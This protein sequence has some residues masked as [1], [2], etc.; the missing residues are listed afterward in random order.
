M[1]RDASFDADGVRASFKSALDGSRLATTREA[2]ERGASLSREGSMRSSAAES[3]AASKRALSSEGS[4]GDLIRENSNVRMSPTI[5]GR[6]AFF[7]GPGPSSKLRVDTLAAEEGTRSPLSPRSVARL[8]ESQRARR[9]NDASPRNASRRLASPPQTSAALLPSQRGAANPISHHV[10]PRPAAVGNFAVSQIT[11]NPFLR[12]AW[13]TIPNPL[14]NRSLRSLSP[15][16][17]SAIVDNMSITTVSVRQSLLHRKQDGDVFVVG[18]QRVGQTPIV[19][20]LASLR[21]GAVVSVDALPDHVLWIESTLCNGVLPPSSEPRIIKTHL[22]LRTVFQSLKTL[23]P[24]YKYV[25]VLREPLDIRVSWFRHC[26][27]IYMHTAPDPSEFDR[28]FFKGADHFSAVSLSTYGVEVDVG[29]S[30]ESYVHEVLQA[31]SVNPTNLL[32]VFA[33]EALARPTA[34]AA[35]LAE[36]TRWGRGN[37]ELIDAVGLAVAS[38]DCHPSRGVRKGASGAGAADFNED[39]TCTIDNMW[40]RLI[41]SFNPAFHSYEALYETMTGT[42][43][44]FLKGG[45]KARTRPLD[46]KLERRAGFKFFVANAV[47]EK[48][49]D[50]S[51]LGKVIGQDAAFAT[52]GVMHTAKSL[53]NLVAGAGKKPQSATAAAAAATTTTTTTATPTPRPSGLAAVK[54]PEPPKPGCVDPDD[55]EVIPVGM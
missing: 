18:P 5:A 23:N 1:S 4:S 55:D 54:P 7:D 47:K 17:L 3:P 30:Y 32:V 10:A 8:R 41:R 2:G 43:Y 40:D 53:S 48:R 11:R 49:E 13:T 16:M 29:L 34:V 37:D 19:H 12:R 9:D 35:K 14:A 21:A 45:L 36:F 33:E 15:A 24:K 38:D 52:G 25:V 6:V 44:P 22:H 26:R 28:V 42:N 50:I 20:M 31:A 51:H 46:A 27:R 39:S